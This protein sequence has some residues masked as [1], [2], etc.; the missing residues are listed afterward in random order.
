M[1]MFTRA[2]NAIEGM[3]GRAFDARG[4]AYG[5]GIGAAMG[6]IDGATSDD[7]SVIGGM[8]NGAF[9]GGVAGAGASLLL[10]NSQST[11]DTV[12]GGMKKVGGWFSKPAEEA[13]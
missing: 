13:V 2:I 5:A 4:P 11:R 6:A 9:F 12:T 10:K 8:A 3:G 7:T 1:A